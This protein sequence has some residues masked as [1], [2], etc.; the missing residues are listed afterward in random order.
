MVPFASFVLF[1]RKENHY[2]NQY[3]NKIRDVFTKLS[4]YSKPIILHPGDSWKIG[5]KH[6]SESSIQNYESD[7]NAGINNLNFPEI[8][9]IQISEIKSIHSKFR[10]RIMEKNN[11]FVK[12]IPKTK[13]YLEDLDQTCTLSYRSNIKFKD[14]KDNQIDII[15][16][17]SDLAYCLQHEWGADTLS[18]N[19]CFQVPKNGNYSR[20]RRFMAVPTYN[21]YG[22]G[23]ADLL[24][25]YFSRF[26]PSDV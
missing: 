11:L 8:D 10:N 1:C 21:N 23:F 2:F 6:D 15:T 7:Y 24:R 19:G 14:G 3:S 20:F 4:G 13:V 18:V 5:D 25:V 17:S 26:K 9:S 22:L 16:S 12:L